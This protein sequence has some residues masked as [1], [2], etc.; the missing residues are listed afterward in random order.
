MIRVGLN[1]IY[2]YGVFISYD[3]VIQFGLPP[4][5][6]M[7][8]NGDDIE[9][10]ASDIATFLSGGSLEVAEFDQAEKD[11]NRHP[12]DVVA[13]ARGR[14]GERG[15][16]IL[17]NNCEHFAY[18]CVT[19]KPHCSQTSDLRA[20]FRSLPVVDVYVA[21]IPEQPKIYK[22]NCA[23]REAEIN[24]VNNPKT[25]VEKYYVWKLLEYALERSFGLRSHAMTFTKTDSGKWMCEKCAFSLSHC[26]GAVS[27][28]LSR[29]AVG[30][31]IEEATR[32]LSKERFANKILTA[33][34]HAIYEGMPE[35]RKESFLLEK[36]T[37]KESM[38]KK[39]GKIAFVP[40]DYDT[41][42]ENVHT[43]SVA[44]AECN[45]VIS[46]ATDTPEVIRFYLDVDLSGM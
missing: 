27:V 24:K 35:D 23:E 1:D 14:L 26:N 28:A 7:G 15:Y 8:L 20:F 36:W 6:R 25:K 30:V 45:Y 5:A 18:D 33:N 46:V 17:Y 38:F 44:L 22:L 3:E 40:R 12:D 42:S 34:E 2:H 31:D 37:A 19:G 10:C 32:P 21:Q 41:T 9:V 4:V 43:E 29:D 11:K 13:Y 39:Q 16:N